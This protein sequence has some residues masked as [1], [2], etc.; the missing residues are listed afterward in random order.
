MPRPRGKR[1]V[2]FMP[3]VRFFKPQ[4]VRM[5]DLEVVELT[6]EE[7]E[8][9]RLKNVEGMEQEECARVMGTSQSTVQR[10]LKSAYHK[11]SLALVRG[12]AIQINQEKL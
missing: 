3:G 10:I 12:A 4:G 9:L 6:S 11:I 2:D 5:R 7:V 1:R 8:A